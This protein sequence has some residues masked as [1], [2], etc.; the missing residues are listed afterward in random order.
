[1]KVLQVCCELFPLVKVGGLGDVTGALPNALAEIGCESRILVPGIPKFMD[2]VENKQ[3]LATI[4]SKF[5]SNNVEVYIANVPD[6][7]IKIYVVN[8]PELYD[9]PGSPYVDLNNQD[10]DDNYQR[11]GLLGYIAM[12][13]S[14]SLDSSWVPNVVHCHDWHAGLAPAYLAAREQ[15]SGRKQASSVFTIHNL[16]YQGLFNKSIYSELDLPERFL[17]D[18][19]IG[20]NGQISFMKA[21]LYFANK[22]TAVSPNYALEIQTSEFGCGLNELLLK[23]KD[24]LIGI[25]N[26][27]DLNVWSPEIDQNI[28]TNFN[29]DNLRGK[30]ICKAGLQKKLGLNIQIEKPLFVVVSRLTEQKGLDLILSGLD[31]IIDNGGQIAILGTGDKKI[32]YAFKEAALNNPGLV[33]VQI[34]YD[35]QEAHRLIAAG[36]F[37]LVPSRFEPCG[38]TQLYGLRYGTIPLVHKV[39]GLKD[40]VV[41]T[42]ENSIKNN[43]ATGIVF[44]KFTLEE[45]KLALKKAFE[46]FEL[47]DK[48]KHV[49]NTAMREDFSWN[50]SAKEYLNVYKKALIKLN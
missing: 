16:V 8:A 17:S 48:W 20:F 38:L 42:I 23:R 28:V 29:K 12:L 39:G 35:E 50:K 34:A 11:F 10:Y 4:G 24:D 27:I 15:V 49:Q 18:D 40:T 36:D 14:D 46:L 9:R 19:G 45:Y 2:G 1:V 6:S 21:G 3:L 47:K 41:D 13:L 32:E 37:I 22:I 44:D 33:S 31:V 43:T 25:L 26:G 5:G 30:A 7:Q